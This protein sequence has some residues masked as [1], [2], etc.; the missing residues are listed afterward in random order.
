MKLQ[1]QVVTNLAS[2]AC[3][4]TPAGGEVRV[5][6]KLLEVD[7]F[8]NERGRPSCSLDGNTQRWSEEP[9][10]SSRPGTITV[11][12]E[13]TD[14]GSGIHRKDMIESKLFSSFSQTEQGRLQGESQPVLEVANR[15]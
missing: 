12:I 10:T 9:R 4:F 14:T 1:R 11:R 5:S 6:T 8:S 3:K 2:N 13:V 7:R 15:S